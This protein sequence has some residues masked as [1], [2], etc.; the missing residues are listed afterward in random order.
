MTEENLDRR[1]IMEYRPSAEQHRY[2][3][4][5]LMRVTLD[6]LDHMRG[7]L[8][9][10]TAR[11]VAAKFADRSGWRVLGAVNDVDG[12]L[13]L[14][15]EINTRGAIVPGWVPDGEGWLPFYF[16]KASDLGMSEAY[17]AFVIEKMMADEAPDDL[18]G[19]GEPD[20]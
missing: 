4:E 12:S 15:I 9:G 6:Q 2:V 18:S 1:K 19:L 3:E 17:E 11:T 8:G 5:S 16:V 14:K 7:E 13:W 20:S 10:D